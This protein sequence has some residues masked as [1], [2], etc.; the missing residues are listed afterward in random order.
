M[1]LLKQNILSSL[2]YSVFAILLL[3]ILLQPLSQFMTIFSD[4]NIELAILEW[5]E[6]SGEEEKQEDDSKGDEE[7]TEPQFLNSHKH[8]TSTSTITINYTVLESIL[9]FNLEI[10]GPPPKQA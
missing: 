10:L 4:E 9:D 3:G 7:K 5:E 2:K 1:N 6:D 8:L